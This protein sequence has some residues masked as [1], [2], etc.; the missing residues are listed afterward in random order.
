MFLTH[1]F[2]KTKQTNKPKTKQKNLLIPTQLS[3]L[4]SAA[5]QTANENFN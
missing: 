5:D 3:T 1:C 2:E 4:V